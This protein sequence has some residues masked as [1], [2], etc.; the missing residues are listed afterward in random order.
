VTTAYIKAAGADGQRNDEVLVLEFNLLKVKK[1]WQIT[2]VME[3]Q[4][5]EK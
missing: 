4:V 2:A 5:L 1:V 3:M